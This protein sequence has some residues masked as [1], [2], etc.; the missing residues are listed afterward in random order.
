MAQW[1]LINII[2][3]DLSK[4][5]QNIKYDDVEISIKIEDILQ[6]QLYNTGETIIVD[7]KMYELPSHFKM[8]FSIVFKS[9]NIY[10]LLSAFGQVAVLFKDNPE[11]DITG[12][13]WHGENS[14]TIY[15]EPNINN[16]QKKQHT[17]SI[18]TLNLSYAIEFALNSEKSRDFKRVEKR[19][20]HGFIK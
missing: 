19:E 16:Q 5:I 14:N 6:T 9:E 18:T 8:Y 1:E 2:Y 11:I 17:E 13:S 4:K 10:D 20:I 12:Y 3:N 15:L 7:E